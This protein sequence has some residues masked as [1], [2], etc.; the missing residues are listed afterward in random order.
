[1]DILPS[2]GTDLEFRRLGGSEADVQFAFEAKKRAIG[3]HIKKRW[4]WDEAFQLDFHRMRYA[5]KPFFQILQKG[6]TI[7]VVSVLHRP[8]HIRFGE[9]YIF[10]EHQ[11]KGLGTSILLHVLRMAD[12]AMLPVRLEYLK[13]NPVGSLYLRNGFRV[14]H[15]TETHYHLE[16]KPT[17]TTGKPDPG[18]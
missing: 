9:F 18:G 5:E 13:W 17:A 15:E 3:P 16:R 12:E 7:G 11:Q 10:P 1:M 14:T 6:V 2:I 8:D 4:T